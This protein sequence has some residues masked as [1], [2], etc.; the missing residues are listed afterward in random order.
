MPEVLQGS[1]RS[2]VILL[3]LLV[4]LASFPA[5]EGAAEALPFVYPFA[6]TRIGRVLAL[7]AAARSAQGVEHGKRSAVSEAMERDARREWERWRNTRR[8]TP[9]RR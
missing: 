1:R 9:W 4:I 3:F 2:S 6:P 5:P 7:L 8:L